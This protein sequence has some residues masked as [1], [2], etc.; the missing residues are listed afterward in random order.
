MSYLAEVD[1]DRVLAPL[2][3][4]ACTYRIAL[5]PRA[6]HKELVP[7]SAHLIRFHSVLA[8][9]ATLLCLCK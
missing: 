8:P 4:A 2:Q 9:H 1:S 5:A 3:A 7:P 6:G